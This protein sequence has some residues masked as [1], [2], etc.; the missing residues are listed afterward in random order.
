MK[1]SKKASEIFK[2]VGIDLTTYK[3][4]PNKKIAAR[5]LPGIKKG[6]G[7]VDGAAL[8]AGVGESTTH[9]LLRS[10]LMVEQ[11][12][13]ITGSPEAEELDQESEEM[14]GAPSQEPIVRYVK[15]AHLVFK[16][17]DDVDTYE[18]L[19]I[20]EINPQ[21]PKSHAKV[22]ELIL[23][24]T[25]ISPSNMSSEDG[26]QRAYTWV[27]GNAKMMHITGLVNWCT[28]IGSHMG[29]WIVR[30]TRIQARKCPR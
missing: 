1:L 4:N 3:V 28:R 10:L 25:D 27:T 5:N 2:K 8:G 9:S 22:E 24:G 7:G 26:S 20:Y 14:D 11:I 13:D 19:W 16:R 15:G 12:E 29:T 23:A 18:E 30:S 21:D 17:Q 6:S